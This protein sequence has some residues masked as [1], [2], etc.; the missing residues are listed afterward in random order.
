MKLRHT[1]QAVIVFI[2]ILGLA[3]PGFGITKEDLEKADGARGC[4]LIPYKNLQKKCNTSQKNVKKWCKSK[5]KP[6][7]CSKKKLKG[8]DRKD[9]ESVDERIKNGENCVK[10]RKAVAKA[11][12]DAKSDLGKIKEKELKA[13]A[14]SIMKKIQKGEKGHQNVIDNYEN[15]VKSCKKLKKSIK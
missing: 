11:F 10:Y 8:A 6:I 3:A 2:A 5:S 12:A 7:S 15:A 13:L 14:K 1:L 4:G 9:K